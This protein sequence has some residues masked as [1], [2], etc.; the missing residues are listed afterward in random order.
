MERRGVSSRSKARL[1]RGVLD[2]GAALQAAARKLLRME[3]HF[4][5][6]ENYKGSVM[7][8]DQEIVLVELVTPKS[9]TGKPH[10]TRQQKKKHGQGRQ[11]QGGRLSG[12]L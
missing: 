1:L 11:R 2:V 6:E 9:E 8:E 12:C 7:G 5:A 10:G 3:H 4:L